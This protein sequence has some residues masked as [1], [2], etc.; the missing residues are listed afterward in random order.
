LAA[1]QADVAVRGALCFVGTEM[2]WFRES[3]GGVPLVGRR[4]LAK[5]MQKPGDLTAVDGEAVAGYLESR[6]V[7]N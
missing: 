1:V 3:L 5:L 7:P 4:G 6:F 2:P